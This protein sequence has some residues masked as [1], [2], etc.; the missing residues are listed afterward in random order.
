MIDRELDF[1]MSLRQRG[2]SYE[3]IARLLGVTHESTRGWLT[4]KHVPGLE[5]RERIRQLV[6]EIGG[7]GGARPC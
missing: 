6:R 4:E 7:A 1:L 2:F 5:A 3:R